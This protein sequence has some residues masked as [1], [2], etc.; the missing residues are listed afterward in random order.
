[1][2]NNATT[3]ETTEYACVRGLARARKAL[4]RARRQI[5]CEEG[6]PLEV[7][8]EVVVIAYHC[9]VAECAGYRAAM[10]ALLSEA[11]CA[12]VEQMAAELA[13]C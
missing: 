12:S 9:A 6:Q 2:D 3:P 4:D 8:D 13:G 11:E 7:S 5:R 1:M 10:Q